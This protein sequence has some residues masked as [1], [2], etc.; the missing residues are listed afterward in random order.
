MSY[1]SYDV[2]RGENL[3]ITV[4]DPELLKKLKVGDTQEILF[5]TCPDANGSWTITEING[6][7]ISLERKKR[8]TK[9]KWEQGVTSVVYPPTKKK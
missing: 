4:A 2:E 6:S 3:K 8:I 9:S 1:V 7:E 5:D